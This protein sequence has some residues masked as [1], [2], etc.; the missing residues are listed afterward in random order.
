MRSALLPAVHFKR[1]YKPDGNEITHGETVRF[2]TDHQGVICA[3]EIGKYKKC[4]CFT[5]FKNSYRMIKTN[6]FN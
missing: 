4:Q 6:I 3:L 1:K 5:I 2:C